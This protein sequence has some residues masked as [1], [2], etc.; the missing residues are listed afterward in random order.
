MRERERKGDE[1]MA[2]LT[3]CLSIWNS[4]NDVQDYMDMRD[5]GGHETRKRGQTHISVALKYISSVL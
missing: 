4:N 2:G 3:H 5:R 1:A